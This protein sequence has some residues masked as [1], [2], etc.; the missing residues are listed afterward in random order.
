VAR[1][2]TKGLANKLRGKSR[3][4][5]DENQIK[6]FPLGKFRETFSPQD[7]DLTFRVALELCGMVKEKFR[8]QLSAEFD[9]K[10]GRLR[11]AI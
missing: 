6:K 3:K 2:E 5:N 7:T 1:A 4:N 9:N 11:H 8:M 10:T